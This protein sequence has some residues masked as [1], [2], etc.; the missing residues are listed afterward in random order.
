MDKRQRDPL[1][2][3]LFT[4]GHQQALRATAAAFPDCAF[5]SIANDTHIVGPPARVAEAISHFVA[6]LALLGLSVQPSKCVAWSPSKFGAFLILLEGV[7]YA[8]EGIR[9][10][11]VPLRIEE[12][13]GGFLSSAL[14]EDRLG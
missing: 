5:P 9:L 8:T 13:V 10:L 6:Q 14:E 11:G 7:S 12:Y 2:G 3:V 1:G 4:L